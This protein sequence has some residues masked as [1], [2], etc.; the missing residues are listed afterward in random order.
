VI[1][2]PIPKAAVVPTC[3]LV[4]PD[5]HF[6]FADWK[7]IEKAKEWAD[8]HEPDLV[9]QLGDLLDQ[10]AW[11]RW[12]KDPDDLS[13]EEEFIEAYEDICRLHKLFPNMHVLTGN[14]DRR[15]YIKAAESSLPSQL[16][17]SM[18]ELFPFPGWTWHIDAKDRLIVPSARGDILFLHGDEMG[19]KPIAKATAL[20][21]NVV[22]GHTHQASVVHAQALDKHYFGAE[23]GHLMDVDSKGAR[24]SAKNP[25]GASSGFMIIKYGIPYFIPN[26]DAP[27]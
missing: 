16:I 20:G 6:P 9:V 3:I 17:K 2:E 11:S 18:K 21:M 12:D 22:H 13:P 4:L 25:K 5:T 7:G 19:G 8:K 10:K 24:Y 27:V 26:D 14:H 15:F 1:S 23:C